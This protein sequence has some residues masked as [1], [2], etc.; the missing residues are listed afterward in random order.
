MEIILQV[1]L[2]VLGFIMLIKGSDWFV[3]GA[4]GIAGRLG[5]YIRCA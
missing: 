4:A 1:G 3:D 2:L 5:Q